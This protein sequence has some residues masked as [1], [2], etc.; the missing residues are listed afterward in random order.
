MGLNRYVSALLYYKR[1]LTRKFLSAYYNAFPKKPSASLIDLHREQGR[2]WQSIAGEGDSEANQIEY[3][4]RAK[5]KLD[6]ITAPPRACL[7]IGCETGWFGKKLIE[8]Y[9]DARYTGI[10]F[11]QETLKHPAA[12]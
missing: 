5:Q 12:D 6:S 8:K 3:E 4:R 9:P 7:E 10:D 11:R 1:N 2:N